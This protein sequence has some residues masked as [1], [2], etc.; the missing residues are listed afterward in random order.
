MA[1][2]IDRSGGGIKGIGYRDPGT[3]IK[4]SGDR[5]AGVGIEG[6]GEEE[7]G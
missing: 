7:I 3:G 6:I 4:R 5:C 2:G 1:P